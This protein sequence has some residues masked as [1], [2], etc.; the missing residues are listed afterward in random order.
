MFGDG[1][2]DRYKAQLE[3]SL[4]NYRMIHPQTRGG[5]EE[6]FKSV[7]DIA[8]GIRERDDYDTAKSFIKDMVDEGIIP[9]S[10]RDRAYDIV[11]DAQRSEWTD[12]WDTA[13]RGDS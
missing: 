13:V 1:R 12:K 2:G 5:S 3:S 9:E 11:R 4:Q 8:L 10:R 7:V 6:S